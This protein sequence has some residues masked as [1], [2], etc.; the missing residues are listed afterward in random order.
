MQYEVG[1]TGRVILARLEH[2]EAVYDCVEKLASVERVRH[3]T[4]WLIG[5]VTN[6]GVVV[7]PEDGSRMP[8]KPVVERF[9]DARE[10]LG[11]GLLAPD[12]AGRP[13]LHLHAAIGRGTT[14]LV[15]C[16][17]EG[18]QCWL[19][20]EVVLLEIEGV[21]A[22]R[23]HD[24]QS[25]FELLAVPAAT[26]RPAVTDGPLI[27]RLAHVC[28]WSHDLS[29]AERFY[30]SGL[31]LCRAFEF[32]RKGQVVGF[33]LRV[34]EGTYI[35]IFQRDPISPD[36]AG[37]LKHLCLEVDDVARVRTRL[38]SMGYEVSEPKVGADQSWQAW[39]TDPSGVRIEFH[40][41]TDASCQRTGRPCVLE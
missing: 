30:C 13:K 32:V 2:G 27:R 12:G 38:Q 1:R 22:A 26:G 18:A 5:G 15:G 39:A 17:R 8:P 3:A 37:P 10:I 28:L 29:L 23:L 20:E 14:S 6:G 31:G 25:G 4:V 41:Y 36:A 19:V 35:E 11:V 40:Q 33:Y 9:A 24:A 16:P 21:Q 34:T 7:G